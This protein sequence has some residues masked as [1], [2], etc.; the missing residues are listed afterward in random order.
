MEVSASSPQLYW[1]EKSK[2][3]QNFSLLR[4]NHHGRE[5]LFATVYLRNMR[6]LESALDFHLC[7]A[8]RTM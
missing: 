7:T 5:R 2:R 6:P 1:Y 4:G 3:T 8:I